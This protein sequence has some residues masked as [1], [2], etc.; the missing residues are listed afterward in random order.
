MFYSLV[1]T[2]H[3]QLKLSDPCRDPRGTRRG[4]NGTVKKESVIRAADAAN[5]AR[6]LFALL[7]VPV[8]VVDTDR[9]IV[10]ANDAFRACFPRERSVRA[11]PH[12]DAEVGAERFDFDLMPFETGLSLFI[13]REV[14]EERRLRQRLESFQAADAEPAIARNRNRGAGTQT[15]A[16]RGKSIMVVDDEI[17]ITSL[18][19]SYLSR[20]GACVEIFNSSEEAYER[21]SKTR[22]D[23]IIC[24]SR[25]P[26]VSGQALYQR[27]EAID[28]EQA[29]RFVFVTG[30]VLD[31]ESRRFFAQTRTRYILKPFSLDDLFAVVSTTVAAEDPAPG[32]R[33]AG[34]ARYA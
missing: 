21:L 32:G 20:F 8:A 28:P 33:A 31:G 25:M 19:R 30:N 24:D 12:H 23:A 17:V 6:N 27:V 26:Q 7:P 22:Y 13:G 18:V 2:I 5:L 1:R 15:L 29:R 14:T 16:L 4:R 3:R 11:I 9:S 10:L 34:R